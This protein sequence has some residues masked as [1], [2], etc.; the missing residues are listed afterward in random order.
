MQFFSTANRQ[1][2]VADR[3]Q[4][5]SARQNPVPVVALPGAEIV[6][7]VVGFLAGFAFHRQNGKASAG[8]RLLPVSLRQ[9]NTLVIIANVLLWC[10]VVGLIIAIVAWLS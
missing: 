4:D 6:A 5:N 10:A 2:K 8:R 7:A 9:N 1:L 3:F